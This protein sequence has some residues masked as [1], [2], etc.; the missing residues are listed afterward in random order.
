MHAQQQQPHARMPAAEASHTQL[1][2]TPLLLLLQCKAPYRL[3]DRLGSSSG[4]PSLPRRLLSSLNAAVFDA[5]YA[6]SW[7]GLAMKLWR[8]YIMAQG[9]TQVCALMTGLLSVPCAAAVA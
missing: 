9:I 6:S 5:A 7:P 3:Q 8:S 1:P 2:H 4:Q